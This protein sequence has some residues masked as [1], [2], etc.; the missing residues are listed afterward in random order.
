MSH[1]FEPLNS[2]RYHPEKQNWRFAD[3]PVGYYDGFSN[4]WQLMHLGARA[5]AEGYYGSHR[6]RSA[7]RH[8]SHENWAS[9]RTLISKR[10][11][12]WPRFC[13]EQG[14]C[15][16]YSD[17]AVRTEGLFPT[18]PG[19]A[20]TP[21]KKT[22]RTGGRWSGRAQYPFS[23][24]QTPALWKF[25]R[26]M[27]FNNYLCKPPNV[28]VRLASNGWKCTRHT[29]I[30]YIPFFLRSRITVKISTADHSKT[31]SAFWLTVQAVAAGRLPL[32]VRVSGTDWVEGGW[33][34]RHGQGA[35]ENC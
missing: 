8:H 30:Y 22:K 29:A 4:D 31:A 24:Y 25:Q 17:C 20:A 14:S 3:V 15:S 21:C 12:V 28:L 32:T 19:R 13:K 34:I 10:S 5:A 27:T 23:E 18:A 16:G 7:R 9:G 11:R 1:L 6:S 35:G 2:Q 33:D 26:F